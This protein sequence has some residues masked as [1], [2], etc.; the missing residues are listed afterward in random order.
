MLKLSDE[1]V[2]RCY[3]NKEAVVYNIDISVVLSRQV[4]ATERIKLLAQCHEALREDRIADAIHL[5]EISQ[6]Y[7]MSQAIALHWI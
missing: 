6:Y 2:R 1:L 4:D 3:P 7:C 5:A